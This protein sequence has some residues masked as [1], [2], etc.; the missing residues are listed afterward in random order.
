L[1]LLSGVSLNASA[2]AEFQNDYYMNCGDPSSYTRNPGLQLGRFRNIEGPIHWA[3]DLYT[4]T[5]EVREGVFQRDSDGACYV[6]QVKNTPSSFTLSGKHNI[7]NKPCGI[8]L[9]KKTLTLTTENG[10][11]LN[12]CEGADM[13]DLDFDQTADLIEKDLN[14]PYEPHTPSDTGER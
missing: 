4:K 1:I 13:G 9:D 2:H 5:I 14:N 6:D 10:L 3:I 7:T 8:E 11:F 12:H